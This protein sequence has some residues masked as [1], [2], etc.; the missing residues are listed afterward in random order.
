MPNKA[1]TVIRNTTELWL[2]V[3]QLFT[4]KSHQDIK[5]PC[6]SSPPCLLLFLHPR[7]TCLW[8]H[9]WHTNKRWAF[10]GSSPLANIWNA[11]VATPICKSM[12]PHNT[13]TPCKNLVDWVPCSLGGC[14]F[15]TCCMWHRCL[16]E[17]P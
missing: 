1:T 12:G 9:M 10:P 2:R 15:P 17:S 6:K 16:L 13:K 7:G 14:L 11:W 3:V 4:E 5:H 8:L